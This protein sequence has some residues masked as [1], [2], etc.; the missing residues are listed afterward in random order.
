MYNIRSVTHMCRPPRRLAAS[1]TAY[2]SRPTYALRIAT[3]YNISCVQGTRA[4]ST[5]VAENVVRR[6]GWRRV[7]RRRNGSRCR[8]QKRGRQGPA[9]RPGTGS[10][11]HPVDGEDAPASAAGF[12]AERCARNP[13]RRRRRRRRLSIPSGATLSV[14]DAYIIPNAYIARGV[15]IPRLRIYCGYCG[16]DKHNILYD[17]DTPVSCPYIIFYFTL[18]VCI[19]D[20]IM[21]SH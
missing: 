15:E 18:M 14:A 8:R 20:N 10:L 12:E 11:G 4:Y 19:H 1:P 13:Q 16:R 3:I 5:H 7:G 9:E 2:T 21:S 6:G 17:R